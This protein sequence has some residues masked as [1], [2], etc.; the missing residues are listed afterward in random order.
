VVITRTTEA[1]ITVV[2]IIIGEAIIR[3][4]VVSKITTGVVDSEGTGSRIIKEGVPLII[5]KDLIIN[6]SSNNSSNLLA[7]N[8]SNQFIP[9]IFPI[10]GLS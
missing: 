6:S 2:A 8:S 7:M 4:R 3:I 1:T 9:Q 5:R 10:T